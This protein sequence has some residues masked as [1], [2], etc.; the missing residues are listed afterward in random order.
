MRKC[1]DVQQIAQALAEAGLF[2]SEWPA[3]RTL[4]VGDP[5]HSNTSWHASMEK[6]ISKIGSDLMRVVANARY[7]RISDSGTTYDELVM[8][9]LLQNNARTSGLALCMRDIACAGISQFPTTLTHLYINSGSIISLVNL[10]F[11]CAETLVSLTL[12]PIQSGNL[13]SRFTSAGSRRVVEFKELRMLSLGFAASTTA[14]PVGYGNSALPVFPKLISLKVSGYEYDVNEL[15]S[16]FP[17]RQIESLELRGT[18]TKHTIETEAFGSLKNVVVFGGIVDAQ[19]AFYCRC[20]RES[21]TVKRLTVD[22]LPTFDGFVRFPGFVQLRWLELTRYHLAE[23]LTEWDSAQELFPD[24]KYRAILPEL[25]QL[26]ISG[27]SPSSVAERCASQ[28]VALAVG[29]P[30]LECLCLGGAFMYYGMEIHQCIGRVL[31]DEVLGQYA[32]H[33]CRLYVSGKF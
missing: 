23:I 1:S 33:L 6:I 12:Q 28:L 14:A 31:A 11:I 30:K 25:E 10:P 16:Q 3:V 9:G 20:F 26:T 18:S 2:E 21:A 13:W 7:L 17:R 22:C 29:M 15:L 24:G 32:Q 19:D 8:G 27:G 4:V 5:G